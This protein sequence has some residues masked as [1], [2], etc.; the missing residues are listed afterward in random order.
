MNI[1]KL[2][3]SLFCLTL[4]SCGEDPCGDLSSYPKEFD[5]L[6]IELNVLVQS[7]FSN[8]PGR[9]YGDS[10]YSEGEQVPYD[11]LALSFDSI[12]E[13]IA[14][15]HSKDRHIRFS[16]FDQAYACSPVT[17]ITQEKITNI[18][19]TSSYDFNDANP[20]GSSLNSFFDVIY[21]ESETRFWDY[22]D[23][24][25]YYLSVEEYMSQEEVDAGYVVQLR[26]NTEPQYTDSQQFSIS[27]SLDSGEHFILETPEIS[28]VKL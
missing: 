2:S 20:S 14:F 25:Y 27:I 6:D 28:F 9:T 22:I 4:L 17:P 21:A 3:V 1:P 10:Q 26:L 23:S 19:I 24:E 7:S 18:S 15:H 13:N 8:F 12:T 11:N 16:I 5:I